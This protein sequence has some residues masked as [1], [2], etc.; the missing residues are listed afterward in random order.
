MFG[1]SAESADDSQLVHHFGQQLKRY[2]NSFHPLLFLLALSCSFP[3]QNQTDEP[4][5][6]IMSTT[7]NS[8]LTST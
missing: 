2:A 8:Q 1:G 6:I 3:R 7:S 4:Q 5:E